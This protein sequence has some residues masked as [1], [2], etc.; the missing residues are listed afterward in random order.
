MLVS[1]FG[2]GFG[3]MGKYLEKRQQH[4]LISRILFMMGSTKMFLMATFAL[5]NLI[6]NSNFQN[7]VQRPSFCTLVVEIM[8]LKIQFVF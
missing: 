6:G 5:S 7:S 2:P 4:F 3:Q 8:F 1:E